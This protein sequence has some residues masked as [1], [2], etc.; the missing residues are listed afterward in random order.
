MKLV[1]GLGNPGTR[2]ETTRHNVGFMVADLV[3]ERMG[4]NFSKQAY[5]SL[6][7]EGRINQ[8]KVFVLK[9]Q[10][11]INLSG[12]AVVSA[13]N[14]YKCSFADVMIIHDDMDIETGRIRIRPDGSGGGHKGMGSIIQLN[15]TQ[16]IPRLRIGIGRPD[17]EA[18][19]DFVLMP[20]SDGEWEKIKP[21]IFLAADAVELWIKEGLT[22]AM[23]KFNGEPGGHSQDN[24]K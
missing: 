8:E 9:P 16:D 10:T 12:K 19:T 5:F 18:V 24:Q 3:A 2:Y 20:F 15:G 23:N 21:A 7:A 1:V 22:A 13:V 14:F 6:L 11:F 17:L 4:A